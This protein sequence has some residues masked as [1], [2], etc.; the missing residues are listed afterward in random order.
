MTGFEGGA[1]DSALEVE[2][3]E[4]IQ[5]VL[6]PAGLAVRACAYGIDVLVQ[7]VFIIIMLIIAGSLEEVIGI[8]LLLIII[9]CVD[10]FY[11][12]AWELLFRGQSLGKRIM[13]LRVVRSNGSPVNPG[14]SFLRNLLRFADTFMFFY[15]I[16]LAGIAASRG[17]RRLGDW[18]G[19][20]LVVYTSGAPEPARWSRRGSLPGEGAI[21]PGR[22]LSYEEKQAL[23]LFA[24]RYPLLGK[25]RAD[26]I[27]R[28][29]AAA[30][31]E[32]GH[33]AGHVAGHFAGQVPGNSPG[34]SPEGDLSD[35]EYLLGI[36][37]KFGRD[38]L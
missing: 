9:F 21:T 19:D 27:A 16:A 24:R 12:A 14:A 26:E 38:V 35:G 28:P 25:A 22:P 29:Y 32:A 18:A 34:V 31:R 20:T 10:W 30:L 36:A 17:F 4:G 3:P 5:F 15:P 2:T 7:W 1:L 23:L 33:L 6:Y 13:G 37:R 8:W 11:H